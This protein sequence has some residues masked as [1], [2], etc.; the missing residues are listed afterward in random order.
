MADPLVAMTGITK[1]FGG[2]QVVTNADLVLRPGRLRALLGPNGAGKSTLIKILSGVYRADGGAVNTWRRDGAPGG[3]IGFVHQNLALVDDLTVRENV[4]LDGRKP[5]RIAGVIDKKAEYNESVRRLAA[6]NA[7]ID[8]ETRLG[9]LSLGQKTL[10]AVARL[11]N[12]DVDV[13][14]LDET[15]AALTRRESDWLYAEARQFAEAGGAVLAVTHRLAEVVKHCDDATVM[16]DGRVIFEGPMPSLTELHLLMARGLAVE[17]P[18]Q[19]DFED[20]E[21][22]VRLSAAGTDTISPGDLD[23]HSGE[24]VGLVGPLSSNLYQIGHLVA[25]RTTA[26]T[27]R[28]DVAGTAAFVPEHCQI[29]GLLPELSVRENMTVSQLKHLTKWGRISRRAEDREVGEQIATLNIQPPDPEKAVNLL[30][31]GNQQKV[32]MARAALTKPRCYVLCEPTRG[33]DVKTRHA[34]YGF[35]RKVSAEGAAVLIITIDVDDAFAVAHKI[36]LVRDGGV[37]EDMH[38]RGSL[39]VATILERVDS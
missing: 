1:R 39:S 27:G 21:V 6:V 4:Y 33:V 26:T 13:M 16:S 7:K 8:P 22:I 10:V 15:S 2:S 34:I 25:G 37:V 32:V 31:G 30:S 24:V 9:D 3:R 23:I 35:I 28:V 29:Q 38:T 19:E 20:R 14:V 17:P 36:G 11:F 18:P 12:T 5:R